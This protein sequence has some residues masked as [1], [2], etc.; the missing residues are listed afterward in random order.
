MGYAFFQPMLL[1]QICLNHIFFPCIKQSE[2]VW[3][4]FLVGV[5][6][7]FPKRI[8]T[9]EKIPHPMSCKCNKMQTPAFGSGHTMRLRMS[10]HVRYTYIYIYI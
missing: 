6:L 8:E 1:P 9:V 10:G 7:F 5:F 2:F 3:S 4:V